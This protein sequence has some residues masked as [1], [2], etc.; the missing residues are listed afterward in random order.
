MSS[1]TGD[2]KV[3]VKTELQDDYN[4]RA[5][6][7]ISGD[8]T[9]S[10]ALSVDKNGQLNVFYINGGRVMNAYQALSRDGNAAHIWTV[11]DTGFRLY[12][13]RPAHIL[14]DS[15][16]L[17]KDVV[18]QY[19]RSVLLPSGHVHDYVVV[20]GNDSNVYTLSTSSRYPI[21]SRLKKTNESLEPSTISPFTTDDGTIL[22]A[23]LMSDGSV[24]VIDPV[25]GTWVKDTA[26]ETASASVSEFKAAAVF[27]GVE[28]NSTFGYL[29][30]GRVLDDDN[31]FSPGIA[32]VSSRKKIPTV[33]HKISFPESASVGS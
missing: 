21:W 15:C 29:L 20:L 18:P 24:F 2:I 26:V 23:S 30:S 8:P 9:S 16:L 3:L 12:P 6:L 7:G 1:T 33:V 31:R 28:D 22:I 17:A 11:E 27:G 4:V 25:K 19:I 5:P 14:S 10:L 13:S 32:I